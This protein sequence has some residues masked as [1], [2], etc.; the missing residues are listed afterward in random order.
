MIILFQAYI[1]NKKKSSNQKKY[2][3]KKK[4]KFD[5]LYA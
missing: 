3:R 1:L 2:G 5:Q 4:F